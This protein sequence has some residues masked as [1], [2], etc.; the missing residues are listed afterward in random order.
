MKRAL[1]VVAV[2]VL[3]AVLVLAA[4][5]YVA[6]GRNR[7]I[8]DGQVLAPGVETVKDGFVSVFVLE[9]CPGRRRPRRLRE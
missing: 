6:F 1:K 4:A 5:F 7:P 3:L 8:A 9:A 2:V